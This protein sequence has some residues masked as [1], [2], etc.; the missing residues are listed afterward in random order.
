MDYLAGTDVTEYKQDTKIEAIPV[1]DSSIIFET[2]DSACVV[3]SM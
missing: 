3:Y 2:L 1:N